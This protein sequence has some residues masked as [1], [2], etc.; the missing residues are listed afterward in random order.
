MKRSYLLLVVFLL[1]SAAYAQVRIENSVATVPTAV[2]AASP[3]TRM[4]APLGTQPPAP[5]AGTTVAM[6]YHDITLPRFNWQ[7]PRDYGSFMN[8]MLFQRFTLP[9][10]AGFL[11]SMQ[12]F[13]SALTP[14]SVSFR[15]YPAVPANFGSSTFYVPQFSP[16][17][18]SLF[19]PSTA[20]AQNAWNTI[21]FNGK[22]VPKEFFISV[23]FTLTGGTNN[24]V[25]V[26][27][28]FHELPARTLEKTRVIMLN[29]SGGDLQLATLDSTLVESGT[30]KPIFSYLYMTAFADTAT[31][32]PWPKI[33]TAAKTKGFV[34]LEYRY[35]LHA[36]GNPRPTYRIVTG[37]QSMTIDHN[38]GAIRWTP[39]ASDKGNQ[40][41]TI[42]AMNTN[43]TD[44]QS[45]TI[46]V[47]DPTAPKI[48]SYPK[49]MALTGEPYFYNVTATGGPD[50]TFKLQA[51]LQ[52]ITIDPLTG[53]VTLVPTAQQ[54]GEHIVGITAT[55]DVGSDVQSFT[56]KIES[57]AYGPQITSQAR[58]AA[59]VNVPYTYQ[60]SSLGNPQATYSLQVFPPSMKID[61]NSGIITWTPTAE[62]QVDVKVRAENRLGID[63]QTY[64]ITVGS[65]AILPVFTRSPRIIAVAGQLFRDTITASGTPAP[66]FFLKSGPP[67]MRVDSV[68]GII[69]WSPAR[70][71]RGSNAVTLEA[72]NSAGSV[73]FPYALFVQASPRITSTEVFTA[74]IGKPYSYQVTAEAEP[75]PTFSMTVAP[76]GLIVNPTTGLITWTPVT[77]QKGRHNV[78]VTATNP[79]G[80]AD[81]A[82]TIDV[83]DPVG[84]EGLVSEQGFTLSSVYPN[85]VSVSSAAASFDYTVPSASQLLVT[86]SDA[87]GRTVSTVI[88]NSV[89]AGTHR[90]MF[91]TAALPAGAYYVTLRAGAV[92]L[93]RPFNIVR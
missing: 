83:S 44:R 28:D 41:V 37:P 16:A 93:T 35:D 4:A 84:V 3:L 61:A 64:K 62:G 23:E 7:M 57:V 34:G 85:P 86:I 26:A 90:A 74:T 81:Q 54:V 56:L 80:K 77:G 5:A 87:A 75:A 36:S 8:L 91:E 65:G 21:V 32:N 30:Q 45:Y 9:N 49:R 20:I 69:T 2:P 67:T 48:T 13:I 78:T 88:N 10:N 63:E 55:N 42:E 22:T 71:D 52:G 43:G 68:L 29:T 51:S 76:T 60:V 72:R 25:T 38:T 79:V 12:V 15:V 92:T 39:G 14:G 11:D 18:D 1:A 47:A 82:F 17:I 40:S 27:G 58:T 24:T 50:P 6:K 31:S 66:R 19:I 89:E 73:E 46:V 53:Q 33:V 59:T 70:D